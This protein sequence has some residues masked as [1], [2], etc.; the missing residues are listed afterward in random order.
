[1]YNSCGIG[2]EAKEQTLDY[3]GKRR[4]AEQACLSPPS[5]FPGKIQEYLLS[6]ACKINVAAVTY[7]HFIVAYISIKR[8]HKNYRTLVVSCSSSNPSF[9][10]ILSVFSGRIID[11]WKL[12][13]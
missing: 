3:L 1:M 12:Y 4:E 11:F 7:L 9:T 10:V 2:Q 6:H 8:P 5:Y 13:P